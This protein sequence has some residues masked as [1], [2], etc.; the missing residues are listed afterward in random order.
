[1]ICIVFRREILSS[2]SQKKVR[3]A[4]LCEAIWPN[5]AYRFSG[6]VISN[7]ISFFNRSRKY[8]EVLQKMLGALWTKHKSVGALLHGEDILN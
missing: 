5:S 4:I 1:M 3:V 6:T 8:V 2:T 7:I